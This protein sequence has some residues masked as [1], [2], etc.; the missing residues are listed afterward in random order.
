M[1]IRKNKKSNAFVVTVRR[2]LLPHTTPII[3]NYF[4]GI[5]YSCIATT[6]ALTASLVLHWWY[7]AQSGPAILTTSWPTSSAGILP[8]FEDPSLLLEIIA[9]FITGIIIAISLVAFLSLPLII[10]SIGNKL[11][12]GVLRA[13]RHPI[14]W[15]SLFIGK[16]VA[17]VI[18]FLIL[19][20]T[21]IATDIAEGYAFLI[22]GAVLTVASTTLLVSQ[23]FLRPAAHKNL[24][25]AW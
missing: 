25:E 2:K 23:L 9:S 11:V 1:S 14:T 5:M 13:S 8:A 10:G 15:K 21:V 19:S 3:Y 4:I 22:T 18:V 6:L 7:I 24:D 20:L 12:R 16:A 17:I